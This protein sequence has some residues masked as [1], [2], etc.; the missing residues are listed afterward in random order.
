MYCV[1]TVCVLLA[2]IPLNLL[3]IDWLG[4]RWTIAINYIMSAVFFLLVQICSTK[5]VLTI[6]IFGVR[7]FTSGIFNAVYIYTSEVSAGVA[8]FEE[9]SLSSGY[10]NNVLMFLEFYHKL[11][12]SIGLKDH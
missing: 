12:P 8:A 9:E 2:A 11:L 7:A 5:I 10:V 1:C 3:T 4:R 6:F